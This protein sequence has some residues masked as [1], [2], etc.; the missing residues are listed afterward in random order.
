[1]VKGLISQLITSVMT[2]PLGFRPMSLML[3]KSTPTIIGKIIAQISTATTRLTEAYSSPASTP[4]R[5]RLAPT[6]AVACVQAV[7]MSSLRCCIAV[8]FVA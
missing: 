7:P 6:M 4:T 8:S 2:S 5:S 1:M 3:P